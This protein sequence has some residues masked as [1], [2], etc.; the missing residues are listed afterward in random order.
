MTTAQALNVLKS[1]TIDE[2]RDVLE[3]EGDCDLTDLVG[4]DIFQLALACLLD[5]DA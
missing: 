3:L 4:D 2:I 5:S 1:M